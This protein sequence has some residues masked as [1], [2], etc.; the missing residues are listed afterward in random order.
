MLSGTSKRGQMSQCIRWSPIGV[1]VVFV[2]GPK[3]PDY[4]TIRNE[5]FNTQP[6]VDT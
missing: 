5:P 3:A 4:G 1:T 2:Q 6:Y